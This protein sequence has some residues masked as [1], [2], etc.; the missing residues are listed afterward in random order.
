MY[1]RTYMYN[2]NYQDYC[3]MR[4]CNYDKANILI[5][6]LFTSFVNNN[7]S[8]YTKKKK[9]IYTCILNGIIIFYLL[10]FVLALW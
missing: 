1:V 6:N 10:F 3:A 7:M 9:Y 4:T 2:F 8:L 5:A